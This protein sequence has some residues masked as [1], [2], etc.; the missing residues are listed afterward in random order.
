LG[1]VNKEIVE[2]SGVILQR[3]GSGL[4]GLSGVKIRSSDGPLRG[5][6]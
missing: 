4:Y 6:G 1:A 3:T 2:S 5:L